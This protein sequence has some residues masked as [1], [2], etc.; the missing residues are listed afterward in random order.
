MYRG[1]CAEVYGTRVT[2]CPCSTVFWLIF[3]ASAPRETQHPTLHLQ[4][5]QGLGQ[6]PWSASGDSGGRSHCA[7]RP[8]L[9]PIPRTATF[10]RPS[11][12]P[13]PQGRAVSVPSAPRGPTSAGGDCPDRGHL[14]L[15]DPGG[16]GGAL[17]QHTAGLGEPRGLRGDRG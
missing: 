2:L 16:G 15:H 13:P 8:Q 17:L 4:R 9:M 1:T 5:G 11:C 3:M 14:T 7:D 12:S 10:P 6:H